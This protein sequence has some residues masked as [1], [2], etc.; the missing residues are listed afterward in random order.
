MRG[1]QHANDYHP[2]L[3]ASI[4][5]RR[6]ITQAELQSLIESL[7][8]ILSEINYDAV[9]YLIAKLHFSREL[10]CASTY[11]VML[12]IAACAGQEPLLKRAN[13]DKDYFLGRSVKAS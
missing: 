13:A 7:S 11:E 12:Q 1:A 6:P 5:R 3:R 9:F 10:D 8:S 2:E 4:I